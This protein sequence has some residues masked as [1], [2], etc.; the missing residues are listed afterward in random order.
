MN[1]LLRVYFSMTEWLIKSRMTK[2]EKSPQSGLHHVYTEVREPAASSSKL[3]RFHTHFLCSLLKLTICCI[4]CCIPSLLVPPLLLF[5]YILLC[6]YE[7]KHR[8]P[9]IFGCPEGHELVSTAR[10]TLHCRWRVQLH[11]L[12]CRRC[13][14]SSIWPVQQKHYT[15]YSLRKIAGLGVSYSAHARDIIH[16]PCGKTRT[17]VG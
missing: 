3:F 13:T 1:T 11:L 4:S 2:R 10:D 14:W 17:I 15:D 16:C 8:F 9:E 7:R 12:S 6:C 5:T